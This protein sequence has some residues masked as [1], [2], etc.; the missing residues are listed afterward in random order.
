MNHHR[1]RIRIVGELH[2]FVATKC[3][4]IREFS[5]TR[6]KGNVQFGVTGTPPTTPFRTGTEFP[7]GFFYE[8]T[9]Y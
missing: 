9:L 3:V 5:Y 6:D 8:M 1:N 2:P 7:G 4:L